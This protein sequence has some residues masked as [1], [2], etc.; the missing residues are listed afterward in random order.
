MVLGTYRGRRPTCNDESASVESCR[1]VLVT[2]PAE[3]EEF[4]FGPEANPFRTPYRMPS[5][6]CIYTASLLREPGL[7]TFLIFHGIG[8][9]CSAII[10]T[11][12]RAYD[13]ASFYD[14]Y[15]AVSAIFAVC[16]RK[17]R[18]GVMRGLGMSADSFLKKV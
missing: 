6:K 1:N 9:G 4:L 3:N 10:D 18:G 13:V 2:M 8:E 12:D 16:T 11:P 5:C 14:I 17:N 15:I 7:L